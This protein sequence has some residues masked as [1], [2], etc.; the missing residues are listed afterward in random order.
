MSGWLGVDVGWVF[1]AADSDGNVYRWTNRR[2]PEETIAKAGPVT[3]RR[4]DGEVITRPPLS[5]REAAQAFA[6]VDSKQ[7]RRVSWQLVALAR[8]TGRGIALENWS[9]FARRKKAW[10]KVWRAIVARAETQRVPITQ[11]NRAYTS[12]T[13]PECGH[14]DRANRATRSTFRCVRCG[15]D[16]HADVVAAMNISAKAAGLF[17]VSPGDCE[18]SACADGV[19][20]KAGLCSFCYGFRYRWGRLPDDLA[21]ERKRKGRPRRY[22]AGWETSEKLTQRARESWRTHDAWGNPLSEA[23]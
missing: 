10:M 16:H 21:F 13:C 3:I 15:F 7:A 14:K 5:L 17:A 11:V 2:R 12:I 9:D 20:W 1:P 6:R 22:G 4:P 23:K 18:N 19:V 8:R